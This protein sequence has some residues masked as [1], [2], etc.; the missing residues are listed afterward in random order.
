VAP[1]PGGLKF[2]TISCPTLTATTYTITAT[3]GCATCTQPDTSM[4]GFTF[5]I[6]EGNIRQ[7]AA[8]PG[9]W[10]IPATNCWVMK[11]GGSC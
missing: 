3:G 7:T 6:N 10:T 11:K 2:F 8:V 1:L 9:G 5:T 4:T